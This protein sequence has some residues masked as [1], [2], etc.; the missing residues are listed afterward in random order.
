MLK[1]KL[2]SLPVALFIFALPVMVRLMADSQYHD[3]AAIC[4]ESLL[5]LALM[6]VVGVIIFAIVRRKN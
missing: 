5:A 3:W 1:Y 4:R 6:P 2:L